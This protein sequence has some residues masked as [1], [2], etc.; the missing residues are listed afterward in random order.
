MPN[1][2]H[3]FLEK[4]AQKHGPKKKEHRSIS[5]TSLNFLGKND[6]DLS[7][8]LTYTRIRN[9]HK[10]LPSKHEVSHR[11]KKTA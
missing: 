5:N 1:M 8:K 3:K 7:E 10:I 9:K 11:E 2:T 4:R 6:I